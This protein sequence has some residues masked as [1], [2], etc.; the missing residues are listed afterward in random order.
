MNRR[1]AVLTIL[2][3]GAI[4]LA[5]LAQPSGR[6]ARIVFL[7]LGRPPTSPPAF[8]VAFF[9]AFK[10][11]MREL[12][13]VEGRTYQLEPRW[14]LAK[15]ADLA[16]EIAAIKPDVIIASEVTARVAQRAALGVPIV[17]IY[18]GDPV[19]G[20]FAKSLAHPGGNVTGLATLNQDTSPKLLELLLTVVPGLA[21]VAVLANPNVPSY[22]SVLKNLQGAARQAKVDILS[23][24]V[25]N[26]EEI[27]NGFARI[28]QEKLRAVVVPGDSLIFDRRQ[29]IA[30]LA[31]KYGAASVYPVKEHADAGGL[32]SY[33]VSLADM[34]RRSAAFVDK[35][36]KGAKPGDLPIQQATTLELVINLKTAK[37]LGLTIPQSVLLR[38]DRVIE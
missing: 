6:P 29:Q 26:P 20:G 35:I 4:P 1:E 30:D 16:K 5:A 17:L 2:A 9:D 14:T 36:L 27:D 21:R 23:I 22:A 7:R 18:S 31:L 37:A 3:V 15:G 28:A 8:L 11:G 33:G 25:R 24:E 32:M 19:A 13:H 34:F 12:G 38:A 10:L